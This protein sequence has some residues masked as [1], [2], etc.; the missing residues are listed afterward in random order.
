[1]SDLRADEVRSHQNR[2]RRVPAVRG[3]PVRDA[4]D[5]L[6]LHLRTIFER[7]ME[8]G[9]GFLWIPVFF[10]AG[11]IIYFALPAEPS[12]IALVSITIVLS[13]SAWAS[14]QRIGAFRIL[15]VLSAMMAGMTVIKLRTDWVM[16]PTIPR[17][18]TVE[19]SGWVA[20]RE[21]ASRGGARVLLRVATVEDLRPA[22]TPRYVRVTIRS[23]AEDIAVGD[24]IEM[25]ARLRPPSGPVIPGGYDFARADYYKSVGAVGFAYG[26]ASLVAIGPPPLDIRLGQPIAHV[27]QEIRERIV[28]AL[29]GD[30][31]QIA[32]ALV[33]GDRRGISES[34][35][36]AMRASG[37][38]H[39]LAISGLHMALVAGSAFWLI[40]AL[41]ALSPTLAIG[42]PIR[43]WAAA[44]ALIVAAGYLSISGSSVATERAFVM[45]AIMLIAVMIDRRAVTVRNVGLA[46][47][48]VMLIEPESVLTASFQMS[49]AATLA[50]VAGYEAI[51]ERGDKNLLIANL[52]DRGVLNRFWLTVRG[53]AL[54]SLIAGLATTPFAIYHFQR[55]APLTLF[56]NLAAMPIVGLVVMPMAFFAVLLMPVG[57]EVLPLTV[58]GWGLDWVVLVAR[59]TAGWSAGWGGVPMPPVLALLLVTTGFL[60][61]TLW[62]ERW[63]LAGVLPIL[64]A[65]PVVLMTPRPGILVDE[66]GETAAVRGM[67][68]RLQVINAK[69]HRFAAEMW[70]RADADPRPLSAAHSTDVRCDTVGCVAPLGESGSV[71]VSLDPAAFADDCILADVVITRFSAPTRCGE[72]VLVID[73]DVLKRGG[74]QA[75]YVRPGPDAETPSFR[76]EAAYADTRRPFNPR[77]GADQ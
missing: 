49:F 43:K 42:F 17:E 56:A 29:P 46:A 73:D 33:M 35:Q 37:L 4:A 16:A 55:A 57:L 12:V 15:V 20:G 36:E 18:M 58:M 44:G 50:L 70:L 34:T 23:K 41:L 60:W 11:I 25:L 47:M 31:G 28:A 71:A 3:W 30:N 66:S 2:N 32:A 24:A 40:R 65:V 1:M 59:T 22:D 77:R 7:E 76:I 6:H 48:I 53:L 54:T 26:A 10:G 39:V 63:R 64:L 69:P 27:R 51:R 8:A 45:L 5:V 14:R 19:V 9:R 21:A 13:V 72:N 68:G 52:G 67:D 38:G 62:R 74:A 61:L 75:I